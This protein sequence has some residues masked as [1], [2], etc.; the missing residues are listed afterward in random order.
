M[1]GIKT[2]NKNLTATQINSFALDARKFLDD[3]TKDYHNQVFD[4]AEKIIG[5]KNKKII[6]LA[7]PSSSGKTTTA[8]LLSQRLNGMGVK[9]ATVSLDDFYHP[10]SVGYPLDEDGKPDYECVEALDIGLLHSC[11][12]ELVK[13]G[14]AM[15]PVFDFHSG[16][17]INNAKTIELSENNV[18]IV[19]GLHAL[20]PVITENLD[21]NK[22]YKIYVSVS[23]RVYDDGGEVLL[24]KRDLRFVRRVVRDF[25]F[26]STSV[27][28]TFEIWQSVMRGEDKYLFPFESHADIKLNSFHACEPCVL[29]QK[30]VNLLKTVSSDE[31]KSKSGQM[32]EKLNLFKTIDCSMLPA[33]S[34]LREFTG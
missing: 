10:R 13:N 4:V 5:N 6:M 23:T 30:A 20:N 25:S 24:S 32:I 18:I 19:E 21:S 8:N 14:V 34:L 2:E 16:E 27:E 28:R 9:T 3:C 17:R 15:F 1:I 22:L 26:R 33:D 31:Y 11:F 12:G 29:S 7:G